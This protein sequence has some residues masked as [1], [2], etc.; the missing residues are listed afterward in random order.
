MINSTPSFFTQMGVICAL[1]IVLV[2]LSM[3]AVMPAIIIWSDRGKES[4]PYRDTE[5]RFL[6]PVGQW[7]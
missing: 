2:L 7:V 4:R 1:G 6:G 5:Y 3:L